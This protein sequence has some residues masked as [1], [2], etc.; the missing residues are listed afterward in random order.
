ME[1]AQYYKDIILF[2]KM[3]LGDVS[4]YFWQGTKVNPKAKQVQTVVYLGCNVLR[5][6]HL[7][8]EFVRIF[9]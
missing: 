6:L 8:A 5:T 2:V 4:D 1:I 9:H 7:A 3:Q